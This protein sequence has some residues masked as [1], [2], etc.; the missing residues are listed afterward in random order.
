MPKIC[1]QPQIAMS[2]PQKSLL[3]CPRTRFEHIL[4]QISVVKTHAQRAKPQ[5][6]TPLSD[7]QLLKC[8]CPIVFAAPSLMGA[9][10]SEIQHRSG[11]PRT[12][13]H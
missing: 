11:S 8:V 10:Y 9:H 12:I 3:S 7:S 1:S 2:L 5:R 13:C 4:E 6:A